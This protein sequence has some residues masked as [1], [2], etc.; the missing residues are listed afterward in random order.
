M[1][2]DNF[3]VFYLARNDYVYV[4]HIFYSKSDLKERLKINDA[5]LTEKERLVKIYTKD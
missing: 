5:D 3:S 1:V 4:L 2:I